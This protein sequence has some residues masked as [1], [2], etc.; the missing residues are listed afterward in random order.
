MSRAF[1]K[2]DVD[3][4]EPEKIYEFR[5]YWGTSRFEIEPAVVYSSPNLADVLRW[6]EGNLGIIKFV[7]MLVGCWRKLT[8]FEPLYLICNK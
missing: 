5:V 8:R 1:V 7:M 3:V 4:P 2:E 6:A